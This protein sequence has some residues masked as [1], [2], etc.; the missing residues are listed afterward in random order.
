[1]TDRPG[2]LIL[3][4][5]I[6]AVPGIQMARCQGYRPIVVDGN[7]EA[8]GRAMA[9]YFIQASIYHPE[10]VIAA[11]EPVWHELSIV[12]VVTVAADNS[13][14]VA[15]VG[16]H[17]GLKTLSVQ[18]ATLSTD[19]LAMKAVLRDA[20]IPIPWFSP[21]D[22]LHHL[23]TIVDERPGSY[24]LKPID[25][26]GSRGVIRLSS[27]TECAAA[28][29]HS[30]NYTKAD[31]LIIEEWLEGDQLSSES[32]VWEGHS[33]LCGLADRNYSRLVELYPHV[34]EDG[35]ETP[36]RWYSEA[37]MARV[38]ALMN[39]IC[40]V[41][42]LTEG[43]IKGD[44]ILYQGQL[45]VIEFATRLS[46]GSFSTITIPL[47][48][49]YDLVGN[50][51]RIAMGQLPVLPPHPLPVHCYQANRFLFLQPGTVRS[52]DYSPVDNAQVVDCCLN[53]RVGDCLQGVRNHTMRSG[54]ALARG[55]SGDDA[56]Q[57][58]RKCIDAMH[59]EIEPVAL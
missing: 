48:H 19:K 10:E 18:T 38:D 28:Y 34:V 55:R 32:I 56:I 24:V 39:H 22:S 50:V 30:K 17:F 44:L 15:R 25:S 11:L 1:M 20:G 16:A 26:R 35:G 47:V 59:V 12:G 23:Q 2:L 33:Y 4:G 54:W 46:G 7:A 57:L 52:I 58:A 8:P 29:A 40:E 37:M 53:V 5:G 36:S 45:I 21:V 6:E 51:F 13:I 27:L 41:V 9:D 42:G 49:G 3:C 43:S 31:Q 14:T